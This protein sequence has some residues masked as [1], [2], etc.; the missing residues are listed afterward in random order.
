MNAYVSRYTR[1]HSFTSATLGDEY[2]LNV[3]V[4]VSIL[5]R[6]LQAEGTEPLFKP[7]VQSV[8]APGDELV[9]RVVGELFE[10]VGV[11]GGCTSPTRTRYPQG[12]RPPDSET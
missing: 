8:A 10:M 5:L 3:E 9:Q 7:G 6:I 11:T 4:C 12:R 1:G 2:C